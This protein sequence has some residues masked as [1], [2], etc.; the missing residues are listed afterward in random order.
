[1]WDRLKLVSAP[2]AEPVSASDL[3]AHLEI[4]HTDWDAKIAT[5]ITAARQEIDGPDG[6][7]IAMVTQTW[8]LTLDCF[9]AFR[10]PLPLPPC[11]SI[12]SV[13]YTAQDGTETEI[14]AE[15][16]VLLS[17]AR[18]AI[19][20]PAWGLAWPSPRLVP[21]AVKITFVAGYGAASAVPQDLRNAVLFMASQTARDREGNGEMPKLVRQTLDRYRQSWVAA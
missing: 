5:W 18:P 20:H 3:K 4:E 11:Q 13:I 12:V 9:P 2:A 16:Y 15:D 6:I 8:R 19:L 14:A 7:G 21:G 1:M 10:I 17:D